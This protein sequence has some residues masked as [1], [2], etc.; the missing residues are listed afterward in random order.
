MV[1]TVQYDVCMLSL[2]DRRY[3]RHDTYDTTT[4]TDIRTSP[5]HTYHHHR[6]PSD[7]IRPMLCYVVVVVCVCQSSITSSSIHSSW[8]SSSS[9]S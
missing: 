2:S 8:P 5:G 3:P 9:S 4:D 1:H 6:Y 7:P